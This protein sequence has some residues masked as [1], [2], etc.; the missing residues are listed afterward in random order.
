MGNPVLND[1]C[2]GDLIGKRLRRQF[3]GRDEVVV[4]AVEGSPFSF[5]VKLSQYVKVLLV[6]AAL[7]GR[8]VGEVILLQKDDILDHAHTFYL[9]GMNCAE[10]IMIAEKFGIRF[11][12]RF[13]L[14]GI[15]IGGEGP[16]RFYPEAGR[17][18][19]GGS[20]S[21]ELERMFP[22]IYKKILHAALSFFPLDPV[23]S[24]VVR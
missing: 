10:A 16:S 19:F 9:H 12:E 7:A 6:D 5:M 24:E 22:V 4:E 14:A 2:I 17:N 13:L 8:A 23:L 1:D 3:H 11:P 20:L 21:H 15:E 18:V